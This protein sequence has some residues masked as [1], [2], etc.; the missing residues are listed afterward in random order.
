MY[1]AIRAAMY[2]AIRAAT[3]A[4]SKSQL[5]NTDYRTD[6]RTPSVGVR[7]AVYNRSMV[8]RCAII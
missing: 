2:V 4:A 5:S 7:G 8:L 6:Y 3:L 1:V